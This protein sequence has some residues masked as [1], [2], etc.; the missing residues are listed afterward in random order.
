MSNPLLSAIMI[1]K[2]EEARLP[3]CLKSLEGVC[4]EVCVVDTGSTDRTPVIAKSAGVRLKIFPWN[5]NESDA[6]NQSVK[7]ATGKW[8]FSIDADEEVSPELAV[9]LREQLHFLDGDPKIQSISVV[10]RNH[11]LNSAHGLTRTVR[12][13]RNREDFC[14]QGT[15]HPY[16]NYLPEV[17]EFSGFLDHYGYQWTTQEKKRKAE[18][19]LNH[20]KPLVFVPHPTLSNLSQYI[21][22]QIYASYS[23]LDRKR[24]LYW[25][26]TLESYLEYLASKNDF[27]TGA[28]FALE[29]VSEGHVTSSFYLLQ[30]SV[31]LRDWEKVSYY[32]ELVLR[33]LDGSVG[34]ANQV[35]PE[36]QKPVALAWH[37]LA[38]VMLG[39]KKTLDPMDFISTCNLHIV[40][41][42]VL[43]KKW[44]FESVPELWKRFFKISQAVLMGNRAVAIDAN[45]EQKFELR[46][47]GGLLNE[48]FILESM[49]LDSDVKLNK[50]KSMLE[51]YHDHR[52]IM[53]LLQRMIEFPEKRFYDFNEELLHQV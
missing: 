37:W 1:V 53:L 44:N 36:V 35:F 2:N 52:W 51:T 13:S 18:H 9:E 17:H 15:I 39:N 47:A 3:R 29:Q 19:M 6:R 4:E 24:E 30:R 50:L 14:F 32:S 10:W 27:E 20:L 5:G 43:Y 28:F 40:L 48:L 42:A 22:H 38:Q 12:I 49:G 8:I 21:V 23:P 26:T 45:L 41:W 11:Y 31:K 25:R 34:T 16:A 33:K 46:S 7:L